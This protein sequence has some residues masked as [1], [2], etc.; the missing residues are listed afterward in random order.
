MLSFLEHDFTLFEFSP[1]NSPTIL[2]KIVKHA[3]FNAQLLRS[4]INIV[5][6]PHDITKQVVP[7]IIIFVSYFQNDRLCPCV[8]TN[9]FCGVAG[10]V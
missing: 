2:P 10:I 4:I 9:V 3:L 7:M 5:M 6:Q 8:N 1:V